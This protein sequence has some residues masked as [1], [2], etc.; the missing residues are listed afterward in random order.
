VRWGRAAGAFIPKYYWLP[1]LVWGISPS[2]CR[3]WFFVEDGAAMIV[4]SGTPR[5]A[6]ARHHWKMTGACDDP[7][8]G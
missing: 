5:E 6:G 3:L 2:R 4:A 1:F 8:T 7:D